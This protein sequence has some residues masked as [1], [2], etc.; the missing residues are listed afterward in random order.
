MSSVWW[1]RESSAPT[2]PRP[3]HGA[4]APVLLPADRNVLLVDLDARAPYYTPEWTNRRQD[5]AGMALRQLFG[6]QLETIV[7]R[8]EQWPR[9]A[10]VE[11]L[12]VAGI[13]PLPGGPAEV[14]LEFD[15]DD[16]APQSLLIPAG[17]QVGARPPGASGLIVFETMQTLYA[18]PG[19]IGE[20]YTVDGRT[21]RSIDPTQP[22]LPFGAGSR[23]AQL[24]IGLTGTAAPAQSLSLGVG[25]SSPAGA[26]PP[27]PAGGVA[28]LPVPP[29]P[30]LVWEVLDGA[31]PVEVEVV[32]DETGGLV[33]SGLIEL[34]LPQQWRTGTPAGLSGATSKRWL[35]LRIGYGQFTQPPQLSFLTL[36][37]TRAVGAR[38]IRNEVPDPIP[39]TNGQKLQLSQTPV[40]ADTL[41]L[42]VDEGGLQ[43]GSNAD[44]SP[45]PGGPITWTAVPDLSLAGPDDRV[46]EIDLTSGQLTFGDGTHG[47]ALPPGF[48]NVNAV[49]YQVQSVLPGPVAAWT[50]TTAIMSLEF[51][52]KVTNPQDVSGGAAGE[53][54]ADAIKRGPQEIRARDRAVTVADYA[55]L[56]THA[57]GANIRRALAVSGLHP[58]YPG[59]PIPGV[60]GVFVVPP[61]RGEGQPTP[62]P[63][64]LRAVA[65]WLA[66]SAAPAGVEI[67]AAA[68]IYQQVSLTVGLVLTPGADTGATV[69]SV[70]QTVNSY[71]HPL[72]GG[73]SGDGWPFG[74]TIR[75]IPLLRLIGNVSGVSAVSRLNIILNGIRQPTCSD[76]AIAPYTLLWP[77]GH[78][79]FLID[80]GATA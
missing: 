34:A 53:T 29:G 79:I 48:R 59:R 70:L 31:R 36:N 55:L 13:T 56:A 62:D 35:R 74:G 7:Q 64:T 43:L 23:T 65:T 22:F 61:D 2:T 68:P 67:V 80:A 12:N 3:P 73:E 1:G 44:G 50:V 6:E 58:Q 41:L 39:K 28:P 20:V 33:R 72:T 71:L 19:K 14:L 69:T 75:Y 77:S 16:G 25:V 63:E 15:I 27:V 18:A 60:V 11:F 30:S 5:D 51:L 78:Q 9:K 47:R 49:S 32:R 37:V 8:F 54:T 40:V 52:T 66:S 21:A 4:S 46:Y 45:A 26:I 76:V 17:F 57:T 38:T 24:L 42:R 10:L